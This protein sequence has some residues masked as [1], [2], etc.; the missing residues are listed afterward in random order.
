MIDLDLEEVDSSLFWE[1][2][3]LNGLWEICSLLFENWENVDTAL[4]PLFCQF[5]FKVGRR[6]ATDYQISD[7]IKDLLSSPAQTCCGPT[8]SS[9]DMGASNHIPLLFLLLQAYLFYFVFI[10]R[11]KLFSKLIFIDLFK[12]IVTVCPWLC[13][14]FCRGSVFI[15]FKKSFCT[16]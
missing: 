14:Y 8:G 11:Q 12:I 2:D 5:F 6:E 7:C 15:F 1:M 9:S 13:L 10:G 4:F 16:F 3:R